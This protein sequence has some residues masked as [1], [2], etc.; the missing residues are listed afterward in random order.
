[1]SGG[2]SKKHARS[3]ARREFVGCHGTK[4]RISEV[5]KHTKRG[6]IQELLML[7]VVGNVVIYGRRRVPIK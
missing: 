5:A 4:V 2:V 3:Q 6:V 7:E 1:M